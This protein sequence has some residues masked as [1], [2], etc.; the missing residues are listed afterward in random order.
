MTST[1]CQTQQKKKTWLDVNVW[2]HLLRFNK[3]SELP[4]TCASSL[5]E[6]ASSTINKC[7]D[8]KHSIFQQFCKGITNYNS[9]YSKY[10]QLLNIVD[11]Y[12]YFEF[13]V[14][15]FDFIIDTNNRRVYACLW[16]W[17]H[18]SI[19]RFSRRKTKKQKNWTETKK[20]YSVFVSQMVKGK[21][22]V[23]LMHD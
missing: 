22:L 2:W 3:N 23:L 6:V 15:Y 19:F 9:V 12:F 13:I 4:L 1:Y 21:K 17:A 14:L 20:K 5:I 7:F 18:F 11:L 10:T 8:R 16:N